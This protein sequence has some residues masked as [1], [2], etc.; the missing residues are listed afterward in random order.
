MQT[1]LADALR[2]GGL[3]VVEEPGWKTR[4]RPGTFDPKGVLVH[5]T[6]GAASGDLPSKNYVISGSSSLPGPLSQLMLSRSGKFHV[7]AAGRANHAGSG[8]W[9][10]IGSSGNTHLIGIEAESVGTRDDWTAAQ[11]ANYPKGVAALLKWMGKDE[12]W[13]I[14]H[15]EWA[16]GRKS[17]PAFWNMNDFRAQ[18]RAHLQAST[19]QEDDDMGLSEADKQWMFSTFA[20][21]VD[22]GFARD[23][24]MSHMGKDPE[25][26]VVPEEVRPGIEVA[27]RVD[28]GLVRDLLLAG[29]DE[30]LNMLREVLDRMD[31][32]ACDG[33]PADESEGE[34]SE[35]AEESE[36]DESEAAAEES[37][38]AE[39][40][41]DEPEAEESEADES[42]GHHGGCG[43]DA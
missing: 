12:T 25:G 23:Q 31:G 40:E 8:Y 34:E 29:N 42:E 38:A 36:A 17:D 10:K 19:Q 21:R 13:V 39:S 20:R 9:S 24:I 30:V 28:V 11:R 37:E 16:P 41:A 14:A 33:C 6:A 27:R 3:P 5:H 35:G 26:A 18:V 1:W 4:G 22:L 2:A 7:I 32:G 15:K 43:A